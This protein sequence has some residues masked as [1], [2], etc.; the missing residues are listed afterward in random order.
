MEIV[1]RA[2]NSSDTDSGA[3]NNSATNCTNA[4]CSTCGK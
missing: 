4:D 1:R 2:Q 3:A